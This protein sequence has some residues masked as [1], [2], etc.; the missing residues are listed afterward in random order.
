[1]YLFEC[2]MDNIH[3]QIYFF[4]FKE[5]ISNS[6]KKIMEKMETWKQE[7]D[8]N[9]VIKGIETYVENSMI[10][11]D[12]TSQGYEVKENHRLVKKG[13]LLPVVKV[14]IPRH[15]TSIL[16]IRTVALLIE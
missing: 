11:D 5:N 3:L 14:R 13:K 8:L 6:I 2:V 12:L 7:K 15:Q 1:M 16:N 4:L 10:V 9:I